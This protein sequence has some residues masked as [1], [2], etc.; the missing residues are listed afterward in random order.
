MNVPEV[1]ESLKASC[2]GT[3]MAMIEVATS[4]VSCSR[5][6]ASSRQTRGSGEAGY[7]WRL[8][9]IWVARVL[10]ASRWIRKSLAH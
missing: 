8:C 7:L 6:K 9:D 1:I 5:F 4:A 3:G 10:V 2:N